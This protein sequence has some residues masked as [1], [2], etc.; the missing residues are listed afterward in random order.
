[1]KLQEVFDIIVESGVGQFSGAGII[2]FDGSK[3]LILKKRNGRWVFPG[4]K[5]IQG[6]TPIQTAKRETKEEVG[7]VTGKNI[8][9]LKFELDE[10]TFHSFIFKINKPFDVTI[11]EE[12]VDYTW[13]NYKK[14]TEMKL[15]RNIIKSISKIIKKLNLLK[16]EII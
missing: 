12:H 5:P 7:M 4:G 3:V 10:R 2:F 9:E 6:E 1:M 11:S 16:V 8:G 14:L 15:H 13:L